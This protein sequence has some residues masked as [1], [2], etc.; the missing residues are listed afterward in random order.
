[1]LVGTDLLC[2]NLYSLPSAPVLLRSPPWLQSFSPTTPFSL[3]VKGLPS[4]W[5]LFLLHS[6]L[7]LVQVPSLFFVCIFSFALPRY[8]GSSLPFGKSEVF[9]LCSVCVL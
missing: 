4:V 2:G 8:V 1:M 9:C 5:K 3:P 6:S 7:P